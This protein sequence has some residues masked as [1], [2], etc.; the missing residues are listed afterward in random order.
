[1]Q[2]D[3]DPVVMITGASAGI[4]AA[5][6]REYGRRAAR[7]VLAARR[8]ERLQ[9]L[10][11]ELENVGAQAVAVACDVTADGDLE[12]TCARAV[13]AFGRIDVVLANAG[14]GVAGFMHKLTLDDYRRQLETNVFG[15][16]RT[17]FAARE[18]LVASRG[19]L[20]MVGSVNSYVALPGVSAYCMSKH[21]VRALAA[22]LRHE[23]ARHGVAVVHIAP[24]FVDSEI[25]KVDNQGEYHDEA[26]EPIPGWLRM[27][28]ERAARSI[29]RGLDRRRREVVITG[30]G[31]LAILLQRYAPWLLAAMVQRFAVR[32]RKQ[33]G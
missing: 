16:L 23:W 12:Q 1:M 2:A 33:P 27:P 14:F 25:R 19:C 31:R 15:V 32:G 6:A 5:V 7:L 20:G 22:S 28:T 18:H 30:H 11:S 8:T 3:R 17:A 9:E 4:G 26:P 21:A 10:V 29:V 13:E 24:G